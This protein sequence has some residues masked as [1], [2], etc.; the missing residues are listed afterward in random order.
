MDEKNRL[1]PLNESFGFNNHIGIKI[2][3]WDDG[4]GAVRV[5]LE[6]H[7]L[8]PMKLIHGGLYTAMLDVALAMTGSFRLYPAPLIPGLT[9]SLTTQ[10]LSPAKLEDGYLVAEARRKGGGKTIFFAEGEVLTP[11]RNIIATATGLFKPSRLP[12]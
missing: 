2:I 3:T 8:N 4:F 12:E 5:N 9:L 7:H 1:D 6:T 11:S 10:F